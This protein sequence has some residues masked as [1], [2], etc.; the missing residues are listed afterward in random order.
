MAEENTAQ[1]ET[2]S[3]VGVKILRSAPMSQQEFL[4]RYKG[5][6]KEDMD[7]ADADGYLVIYPHPDGSEYSSWSP[8]AV[9]E[10]AYRDLQPFELDAIGRQGAPR[11]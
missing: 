7:N 4:S 11:E 8:K 10:L 2:R 1:L 6:K 3:C 9:Y 5:V